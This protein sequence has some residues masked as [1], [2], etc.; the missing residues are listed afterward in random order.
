MH[1]VKGKGAQNKLAKRRLDMISG[2]VSFYSRCLN[3]PKRL[4]QIKEVNQLAAT[5]ASATAEMDEE[6]RA[7]IEKTAQNVK[8]SKEKKA[9]KEAEEEAERAFE[10]PKLKPLMNDFETGCREIKLLNTPMFPKPYLLKMLKQYCN[11]KPTWAQKK[12]KEEIVRFA[13]ASIVPG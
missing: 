12:T 5:V 3:G 8:V 9:K 2:N 7:K 4:K 13:L 11:A 6:K 1:D 10:L